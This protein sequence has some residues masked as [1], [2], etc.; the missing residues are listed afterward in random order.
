MACCDREE[1]V[2]GRLRRY[3][4]IT[5]TGLEVLRS[6]IE[7]LEANATAARGQLARRADPGIAWRWKAYRRLLRLFPSAWRGTTRRS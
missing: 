3:Y 1:I 7:R 2:G 6:G 4:R 5:E